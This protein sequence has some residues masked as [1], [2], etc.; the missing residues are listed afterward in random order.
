MGKYD[1]PKK[2]YRNYNSFKRLS[3]VK[4]AYFYK[5]KQNFNKIMTILVYIHEIYDLEHF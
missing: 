3:K 1:T 2:S 4:Y 5:I